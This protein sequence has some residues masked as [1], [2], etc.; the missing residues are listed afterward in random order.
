MTPPE[1]WL[2]GP[3]PGY[4]ALLQPM[5]HS[6]TQVLEEVAAVL[7]SC[8]PSELWTGPEGRG[9]AGFHLRHAVGSLERLYT[10]ARG[11]A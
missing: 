7:P 11:E 5:A 3:L 8:S 6:L 1:V 2:R 4:P 9:P 10:Y